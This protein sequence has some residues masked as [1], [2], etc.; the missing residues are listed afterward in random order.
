VQRGVRARVE[1]EEGY[2]LPDVVV[3]GLAEVL[4]GVCVGLQVLCLADLLEAGC[5]L[6]F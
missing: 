5:D 2:A 1:L 6:D 4:Q 3:H